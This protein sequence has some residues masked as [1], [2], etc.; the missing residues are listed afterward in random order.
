MKHTPDCGLWSGPTPAL[1]KMKSA[2]A[3]QAQSVVPMSSPPCGATGLCI[4]NRE[5]GACGFGF[6][7]LSLLACQLLTSQEALRRRCE[8]GPCSSCRDVQP[9]V[10]TQCILQKV[11]VL[12]L[13]ATAYAETVKSNLLNNYFSVVAIALSHDILRELCEQ[14]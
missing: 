9:S 11:P 7:C 4:Y 1:D 6:S 2:P 13:F 5:L 10:N 14:A 12:S 8:C 3:K